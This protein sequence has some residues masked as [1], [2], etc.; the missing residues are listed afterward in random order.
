MWG[1]AGVAGRA[2]HSC[3]GGLQQVNR[4]RRARR[5][6]VV[7]A[8]G[9][10][11]ERGESAGDA[12]RE[13]SDRCGGRAPSTGK[14]ATRRPE[15][16][17]G[18]QTSSAVSPPDGPSSAAVGLSS[19]RMDWRIVGIEPDVTSWGSG[20][21]PWI[22]SAIRTRCRHQALDRGDDTIDS[23]IP[24]DEGRTRSGQRRVSFL[25]SANLAGK[26]M[27][28]P[29]RSRA[30]ASERPRAG[31]PGERPR[32]SRMLPVPS[33]DVRR[34]RGTPRRHEAIASTSGQAAIQ[35]TA[36]PHQGISARLVLKAH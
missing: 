27:E 3:G 17:A 30:G 4:E 33:S 23:P 32:R 1:L 12:G 8:G 36:Y 15:A 13:M 29:R 34:R 14:I 6:P 5:R 19:P 31:R 20:V 24:D 22:D 21:M 10:E 18:V 16:E 11:G 28:N 35:F 9:W 7:D 26:W 2:A 25:V